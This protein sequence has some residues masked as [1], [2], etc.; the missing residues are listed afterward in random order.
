M[1]THINT[2]EYADNQNSISNQFS[3]LIFIIDKV[4]I[5]ANKYMKFLISG[6]STPLAFQT[7]SIGS[8]LTH[9]YPL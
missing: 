7:S 1:I 9:K 4:S 6:S 2:T 3:V 8:F 5:Q